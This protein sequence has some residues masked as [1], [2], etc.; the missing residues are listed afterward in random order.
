MIRTIIVWSCTE[1]YVVCTYTYIEQTN[2]AGCLKK[3]LLL[4]QKSLQLILSDI[5]TCAR[6]QTQGNHKTKAIILQCHLHKLRIS[7]YG[8][9]LGCCK[10]QWLNYFKFWKNSG[11]WWILG[12]CHDEM[13]DGDQGSDRN[14]LFP[15]LYLSWF[16][17]VWI[18]ELANSLLL[19]QNS[20][21]ATHENSSV[22]LHCVINDY[23]PRNG[24]TRGREILYRVPAANLPLPEPGRVLCFGVPF[25]LHNYMK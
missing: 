13:A 16:I 6:R 14:G 12:P 17:T 3:V 10:F 22:W 20:E 18:L 15:F 25:L 19:I 2:A 23:Q 24:W 9:L 1:D 8:I 4:T 7:L 11:E 21:S 5:Q